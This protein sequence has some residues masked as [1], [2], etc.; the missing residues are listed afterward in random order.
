[1]KGYSDEEVRVIRAVA[2]QAK[3]GMLAALDARQEVAARSLAA[4]GLLHNEEIATP[5]VDGDGHTAMRAAW[6]FTWS[7]TP[8]GE[9]LYQRVVAADGGSI[10]D[11]RVLLQ[12]DGTVKHID[13]DVC[14]PGWGPHKGATLT[15]ADAERCAAWKREHEPAYGTL[16]IGVDIGGVI[17]KYPRIIKRIMAALSESQDIEVHVLTDMPRDKALDVMHRNGVPVPDNRVHSC[18]YDQHG[19][20]CKA[21]K[22]AELG[23][24][25]MVDDFAAYVSIPN[26]PPLRLFVMPDAGLPYYADE[27]QMDGAEDFGRKRYVQ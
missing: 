4:R 18:S 7:F 17:S 2:H 3:R 8:A 23:L 26:A 13:G 25:V 15:G 27:W 9:A 14:K 1:M 11:G 19:E 20:G 5:F 22:S 16:R 21:A 10:L 12:P 24:H 6:G